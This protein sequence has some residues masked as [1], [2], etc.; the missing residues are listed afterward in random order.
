MIFLLPC[1]GLNEE[2]YHKYVYVNTGPGMMAL[3]GEVT[4]TSRMQSLA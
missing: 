2:C 3:F 4:E 1:D